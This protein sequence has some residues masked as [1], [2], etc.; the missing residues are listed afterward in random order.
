MPISL[1]L[2][3]KTPDKMLMQVGSGTMV[4]AKQVYS[5]GKGVSSSPM[6]GETKAIEGDELA[7][8]KEAAM[9]F[10]E[11]YY[12]SLGYAIEL[13]GIEEQKDKK[14]Y[15]KVQVTKGGD[16]KDIEYYDVQSGLKT[17]AESKGQLV[18]YSDYK[19]VDGIMFPFG[20]TQN[21]GPQT[22]KFEVSAVKI[23][24]KLK[25]EFFEVK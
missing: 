25:D 11:M 14:Q 3:F 17:R 18:D 15:Y 12:K 8:M 4:F 1:D 22:I 20:M 6:S 16:K 2:Y 10:P 19:P 9:I 5:A 24:T 13:L 23:N 21:M 7:S